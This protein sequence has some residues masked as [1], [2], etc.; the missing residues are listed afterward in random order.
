MRG[1]GR[2]TERYVVADAPVVIALTFPKSSEE[3]SSSEEEEKKP[4]LLFRPKFVP[5]CVSLVG[6]PPVCSY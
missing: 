4:K 5:K 3:E 2:R 6:V 1:Q